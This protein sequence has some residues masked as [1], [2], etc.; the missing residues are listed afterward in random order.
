MQVATA[1][2][3][4][5]HA[6]GFWH[7]QS[8][9][10]RDDF[11]TLDTRN[12]KVIGFGYFSD[13]KDRLKLE[14][15]KL[16]PDWLKQFNKET[17]ATNNNYDI[18]YDYGSIMHYGYR[19]AS[20]NNQPTMVPKDELYTRSLGSPFISFYELLMMNKHYKCLEKCERE[21]SA[22]CQMDGFPHPRDCKKCICPSGFGGDL[23]DQRPS[24]CGE[25]LNA[26]NEYQTLEDTLGNRNIRERDAMRD[27][28]TKCNYWIQAPKG[29]RIEVK[30]ESFT[31]PIYVDGCKYVGVEIKTHE[32]LRLTGYRF[33][34]QEDKGVTLVSNY[35]V[36]PVITYNRAYYSTTVLK[37][38]IVTGDGGRPGN[39]RQPN[40]TTRKP[41]PYE[42]TTRKPYGS[43]TKKPMTNSHCEDHKLCPQLMKLRNFCKDQH[44]SIRLRAG[45]CKKSCNFC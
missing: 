32:D 5:G 13:K 37:Y 20:Y 35:H 33:C 21:T 15:S 26:T 14:E 28:F 40:A 10:D 30:L 18:T 42:N 36:V 8:R 1:A 31:S 39:T 38:R 6:L 25:V 23:C 22:T 34:A 11:I 3:E 24:G 45:V 19:S 41:N 43:T 16:Q 27:D 2:H 7:T 9:Y 44:Y 4:I 17:T 29:S 12:I